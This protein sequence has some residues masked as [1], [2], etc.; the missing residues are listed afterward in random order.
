MAR[1]TVDPRIL[2]K[3]TPNVFGNLDSYRKNLRVSPIKKELDKII[4]GNVTQDYV[5]VKATDGAMTDK[6]LQTITFEV[7]QVG[8]DCKNPTIKPQAWIQIDPGARMKL[9]N[10]GS[11]SMFMI[12][13]YELS[14]VFNIEDP[15]AYQ[16]KEYQLFEEALNNQEQA[17]EKDVVN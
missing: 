11:Q 17:I 16:L 1:H 4:P 15:E 14:F 10:W 2:K 8:P 13:E 12:R 3:S 6:G 5:L 7:L 9:L